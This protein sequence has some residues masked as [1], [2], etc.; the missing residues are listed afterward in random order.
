MQNENRPASAILAVAAMVFLVGAFVA[1]HRAE[2]YGVLAAASF[3]GAVFW[4][5]WE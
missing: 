2:L 4:F 3:G 5:F 1:P